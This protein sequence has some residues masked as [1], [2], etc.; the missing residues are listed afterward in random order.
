MKCKWEQWSFSL[1]YATGSKV[2]SDRTRDL[3]HYSIN[4][5]LHYSITPL[6][7]HEHMQTHTYIHTQQT[8]TPTEDFDLMK[9]KVPNQTKGDGVFVCV[10]QEAAEGGRLIIMAGPERSKWKSI[11]SCVLCIWYHSTYST[12]SIPMS[13]SSPIKVPPTSC[14]VCV[15]VCACLPALV[16]VRVHVC[17]YGCLG[18]CVR[19]HV[20]VVCACVCVC[21]CAHLCVCVC[22]F[23]CVL[24]CECVCVCESFWPNLMLPCGLIR[25]LQ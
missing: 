14:G 5:L 11:K 16:C 23:T 6:L 9:W 12:P 19:M 20:C 21:I 13:P 4:P 2:T 15:C 7:Y 8:H 1:R 25:Q 10:S 22:A 3:L 18:S 17:V 24:A